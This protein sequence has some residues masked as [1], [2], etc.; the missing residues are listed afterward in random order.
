MLH[1]G[2]GMQLR[3]NWGLWEG[4]ELTKYFNKYGIDHPDDMTD[5][6]FKTF[7]RHLNNKPLD[8]E[9]LAE[10]YKEYWKNMKVTH[11]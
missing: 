10:K 1:F 7:W 8:I 11:G 3:N 6:I 5:A 2:L 9:G 4:S